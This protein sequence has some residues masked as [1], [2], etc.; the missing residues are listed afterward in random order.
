MEENKTAFSVTSTQFRQKGFQMTFSN[1]CTISVVFGER[2]YSDQGE[3]T[4]EVAA[5]SGEEWLG[6]RDGAWGKIPGGG[7]SVLRHQT[8]DQVA[9]LIQALKN[10]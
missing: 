5:W 9:D 8:P 10:F 1:G 6:Y 4:A 2:T 3:S 7:S